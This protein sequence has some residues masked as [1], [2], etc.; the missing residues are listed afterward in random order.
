LVVLDVDRN[1]N[2]LIDAQ[3]LTRHLRLH[4][5]FSRYLCKWIEHHYAY[6]CSKWINHY[7]FWNIR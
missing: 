5:N 1:H 2:R 6:Y 4:G 3:G 7:L